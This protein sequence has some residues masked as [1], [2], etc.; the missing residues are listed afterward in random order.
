MFISRKDSPSKTVFIFEEYGIA[1]QESISLELSVK[2]PIRLA[3][4]NNSILPNT[5]ILDFLS[6][7]EFNYLSRESSSEIS[8]KLKEM[9]AE[10]QT[11][12]AHCFP[13]VLRSELFV[14]MHLTEEISV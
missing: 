2:L 11:W 9:V 6:S 4:I 12:K 8:L 10:N 7:V 13:V 5:H 3:F 1:R 14:M